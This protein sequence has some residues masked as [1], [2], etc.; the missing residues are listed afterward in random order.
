MQ[1]SSMIRLLW[2]A[3][4]LWEILHLDQLMV[5]SLPCWPLTSEKLYWFWAK[6]GLCIYEWAM[7]L[8][9]WQADVSISISDLV[10]MGQ[11]SVG[12]HAFIFG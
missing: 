7:G 4:L 3:P 12:V 9:C 5:I 11:R 1:V 8:Q 10:G 6:A 2:K